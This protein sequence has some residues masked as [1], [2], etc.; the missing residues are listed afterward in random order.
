MP[1]NANHQSSMKSNMLLSAVG[2][3]AL[4]CLMSVANAATVGQKAPDF[5]LE[6]IDGKMHALSDFAGKVVVL[7]WTNYG[8]PFVKKHYNSGNMQKLQA[9]A[10][11]KDVVW[12]S[13]CSSAEG[14]QGSM[15][16]SEWQ[17][18]TKERG[19]ESAAV[20]LDESGKVGRLYGAIATP[21]MFVIDESGTLVYDGAI[22]SIPSTSQADIARTENYV[23]SA[24]NAALAGQK[25]A[26]PKNKPYGCDIKYA[27]DS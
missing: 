13:I 15:S 7:E 11:G 8:C 21:H 5:T 3:A 1:E 10:K 24:V 16:P 12:L 26:K 18:A 27:R 20:L 9:E 4:M 14:K 6:S 2:A 17:A 23:T 19:V 22:D 25:V